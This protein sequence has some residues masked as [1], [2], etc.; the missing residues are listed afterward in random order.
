MARRLAT[1]IGATR[2][3]RFARIYDQKN[4]YFHNVRAIRANRLKPAIRNVLVP[5]T[6]FAEKG[7]PKSQEFPTNRC[8]G[9]RQSITQ[10]GVHTHPLTAWEREH[11]FLQHFSH[12]LAANFGGQ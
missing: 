12:F 7:E 6:R 8:L 4:P 3:N 9:Q 5:Q 10:K 11:W 2:T 1:R